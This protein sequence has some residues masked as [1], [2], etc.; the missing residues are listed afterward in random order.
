MVLFRC[1]FKIIR[2]MVLFRCEFK[3]IREMPCHIGPRAVCVNYMKIYWP[4][5]LK[6]VI[7]HKMQEYF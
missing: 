3:I 2:E 1:E 7:Y 6:G 5:G 4:K